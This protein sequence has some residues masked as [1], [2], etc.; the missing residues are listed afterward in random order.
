MTP[1]TLQK[2][3]LSKTQANT[4]L[5]LLNSGSLSAPE[6]AEKLSESRTN[7]YMIL[8][9]LVS[10]GLSEKREVSGKNRYFPANPNVLDS[11]VEKKRKEVL[12]ADAQ[13]KIA[14]PNL[15]TTYFANNEQP[16]VRFYEGKEALIK[17]YEDQL[18][19]KKDVYFVRTFADEEF[20]GKTLYKYMEK[21]AKLDLT[22]YGLAPAT[23]E[24]L[25]YAKQNDAKLKRQ[26]TWLPPEAYDAP[27]EIDIYGDKVAFISFGKEAV[28]TIVESPQIAKAMKQAF[29]LMKLGAK[30]L[31]PK[32]NQIQ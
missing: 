11:L 8:D 21:R 31:L 12:E 13:V 22:A 10:L 24:T 14:L 15:I 3:G 20:L 32:E 2:I 16:G 17:M 6:L 23:P 25:E 1:E 28:G 5:L 26:M 30:S 29:E 9:K 18:R 19:T 27:V 7:A 4:Y